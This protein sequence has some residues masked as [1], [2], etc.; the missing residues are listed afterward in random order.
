MDESRDGSSC[1]QLGQVDLNRYNQFLWR[2]PLIK[3][4]KRETVQET[5]HTKRYV[6]LTR[7]IFTLKQMATLF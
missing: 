2:R 1:L 5:Y 4:Q 3:Q 6:H 7:A